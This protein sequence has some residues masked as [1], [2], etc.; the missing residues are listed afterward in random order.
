VLVAVDV[1]PLLGARTG[2]ARTVEGLLGALPQAAP[3]ISVLP[4]VLSGRA[5]RVPQGTRVLP[6]PASVALRSWGRIGL[7][8]AD[9][10]LGDAQVVHGTNFA[11]PPMRDR[12]TTVTVH[13]CWCAR[14]PEL[15][16]PEWVALSS[17]VQM[18]V[19]RGAWIH[20]GT[21]WVASEVR[22]VY[23][24]ER[25]EVVPF[26]A[27]DVGEPGPVAVRGPFVLAIATLD[28]RKGLH[29]LVRAFGAVAPERPDLQL[30]V[31]GARGNAQAAVVAAVEDLGPLAH[32]VHLVGAADDPTRWALLHAATVLAFPS[33]DE[34]F[35]FPVLEAMSCGTPVVATAVGGVPEVAGDAAELVPVGD[36][37]ALATA[38]ARVVDDEAV[39]ARLAAAGPAQA[40]RFTWDRTAAGM[41]ALWAKAVAP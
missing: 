21:E 24:A 30:V 4:Y 38:L 14:H 34:G 23:G 10:W 15:C 33:L 18:A 3:E 11:V 39:R 5:R 16:R 26:G 40:A 35:G 32:R 28:R 8:R 22:D 29:H 12:P 20:V 36:E 31:V 19:D 7:P 1:T 17:T 2:V 25:I 41:A 6:V 9:R 27:P 37:G 13:D